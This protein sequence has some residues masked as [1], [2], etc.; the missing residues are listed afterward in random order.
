M[1]TAVMIDRVA[2]AVRAGDP[3]SRSGLL[4]QLAHRHDVRL[5]R[6]GD[7]A[8]GAVTVLLADEIGEPALREIRALRRGD[9]GRVVVVVARLDDAGLLGA[10]EAG[11]SSLLRR[12]EVTVDRIVEAVRAAAAGE[13]SMPPDLLGRLLDHV[14]RVQREVL[15]PR[16]LS[17][18]LLSDREIRVL[19]LIADGLDTVEVGR[20][21]YF[22]ERTVKNIVH[23][24]TSRL[25]LRNR[26]H[27]VAFALRQGLI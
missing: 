22:S 24:V 13:G 21:L 9:G 23:D 2:V 25:N 12:D 15:S 7:D 1:T 26:T 17:F 20:R 16:G 18:S 4:A 8:T 14:G 5:L 19:R 3:I 11:A 6:D 27:A 10:V